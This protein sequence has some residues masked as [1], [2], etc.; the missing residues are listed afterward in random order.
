[1]SMGRQGI[2]SFRESI[3]TID[4]LQPKLYNPEGGGILPFRNCTLNITIKE[5]TRAEARE[6]RLPSNKQQLHE[7]YT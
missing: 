2:Q 7:E 6:S 5:L 1:M 4:T 3:F